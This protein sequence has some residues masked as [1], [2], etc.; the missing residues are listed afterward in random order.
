MSKNN[1]AR[2]KFLASL[3]EDT[4]GVSYFDAQVGLSGKKAKNRDDRY[5]FW[6]RFEYLNF[7]NFAL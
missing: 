7:I 6:H 3:V 4:F 1:S 2:M 5:R